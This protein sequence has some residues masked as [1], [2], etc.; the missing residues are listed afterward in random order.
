MV[1]VGHDGRSGGDDALELGRLLARSLG[2]KMALVS[3][4][5]P[6][7]SP[8]VIE[9]VG[10]RVVSAS[11]VARGLIDVA[12]E[13]GAS[14]VVV[15]SSHRGRI[16]R[17]L[18]GTDAR[19]LADVASCPVAV[20]PRGYAQRYAVR[21]ARVDVRHDGSAAGER[22]VD[23]AG[24]IAAAEDG[25]VRVL[26]GADAAPGDADL[27]ILGGHDRGHAALPHAAALLM[28]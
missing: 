22:A 5:V 17:V 1:I 11:S 26:D 7:A 19:H 9:G 27:L 15:G 23:L 21:L 24:R 18:F 3:V 20:A 6:G 10:G 12:D 8:A 2:D 4:L 28:V 14:A 13:V 25:D 16:G